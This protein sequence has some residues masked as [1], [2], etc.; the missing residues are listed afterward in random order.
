MRKPLSYFIVR[1]VGSHKTLA[2]SNYRTIHFAFH[3]SRE[4]SGS[5][6]RDVLVNRVGLTTEFARK[7]IQ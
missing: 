3:K 2:S 6:V 1:N 7:V 4:L 5:E